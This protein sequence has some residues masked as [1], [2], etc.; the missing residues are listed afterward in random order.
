M[1]AGRRWVEVDLSALEDARERAPEPPRR[2]VPRPDP[3][4]VRELVRRGDIATIARVATD[5][6]GGPVRTARRPR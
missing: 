6:T 3:Q 1:S 2:A 5:R 4:I